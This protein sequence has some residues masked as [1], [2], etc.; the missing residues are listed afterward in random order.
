MSDISL[1]R[2]QGRDLVL[3]LITQNLYIVYYANVT[4]A[5]YSSITQSI[6]AGVEV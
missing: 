3:E 5:V 6:K 1:S 2:K 4:E